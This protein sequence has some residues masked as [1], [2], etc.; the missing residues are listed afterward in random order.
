[1]SSH[2]HHALMSRPKS[3]HVCISVLTI[4]LTAHPS[5]FGE[6]IFFHAAPFTNSTTVFLVLTLLRPAHTLLRISI[7]TASHPVIFRIPDT[8]AIHCCIIAWCQLCFQGACTELSHFSLLACSNCLV[9]TS[10]I[11][12]SPNTWNSPGNVTNA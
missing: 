2:I 6:V 4:Y 1:M 10:F 12:P 3:A 5:L 9:L 8:P 7:P 11:V